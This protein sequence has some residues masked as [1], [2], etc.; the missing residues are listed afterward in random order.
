MD[1]HR[2]RRRQPLAP[3]RAAR[4]DRPDAAWRLVDLGARVARV[5]ERGGVR[6]VAWNSQLRLISYA[7]LL[8]VRD[9]LPGDDE[10]RDFVAPMLRH[11]L[12]GTVPVELER[13]GP[14]E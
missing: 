9:A 12:A 14:I 10:L 5:L 3:A 4:A 11:E 7:Y 8:G 2:L 1:V 6:W 13:P